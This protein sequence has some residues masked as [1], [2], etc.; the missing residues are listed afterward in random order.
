[1]TWREPHQWL[2]LV[3]IPFLVATY[4]AILRN[5]DRLSPQACRMSYMT[6]SYALETDFNSS[7]TR[8]ARR[9][10]LWLYREYSWESHEKLNGT[11]VLFIPGNAGSSRQVRSIA[12]S[13]TRQYYSEPYR[14]S[15]QFVNTE[16]KPL[17]VFAV[18]FNEDFSALHGPTLFAEREYASAAIDFI[19]SRYEPNTTIIVMGHSMGGIVALSLLPSPRISTIITMSTP[20]SL[21]PA[22]L[23]QRIEEIYKHSWDT[24]RNDSTSIL[25]I[26]GGATDLM[27][28]S[29]TC[30]MQHRL[31]SLLGQRRTVSTTCMEGAWTGVGHREMVWCHQVR[32]RVARAAIELGGAR[33][34]DQITNIIDRWFRDEMPTDRFALHDLL[35]SDSFEKIELPERQKLILHKIPSQPSLFLIPRSAS[36]FTLYVS[37]GGLGNLSPHHPAD[38]EVSVYH[39]RITPE[40]CRLLPADELRLIPDS[41]KDS[42]FLLPQ[43]GVDES[44]GISRYHSRL[45]NSGGPQVK[46]WVG[47]AVKGSDGHKSWIIGGFEDEHIVNLDD[48]AIGQKSIVFANLDAVLTSLAPLRGSIPVSLPRSALSTR[49][50]FPNLISSSL[51]VYR[52]DNLNIAG[53]CSSALLPPLILHKSNSSESHFHST[54]GQRVILIHTHSSGPF[55]PLNKE[56]RYGITL[57][58]YSSGECGIS[59]FEFTVDWQATLATWGLRYWTTVVAWSIG[60]VAIVIGQSWHEWENGEP[61]LPLNE[62]L[63]LFVSRKLLPLAGGLVFL[64][65]LPLNADFLLG[66]S[67]EMILSPLA[68]LVLVVSSGCVVITLNILDV[69]VWI[70]R[71]TNT[72]LR[73]ESSLQMTHLRK[74]DLWSLGVVLLLVATV[75]PSQVAFLVCFLIHLGTCIS[76][77]PASTSYPAHVRNMNEGGTQKAHFLLLLFWLLP[78]TAP[79]L[80]V[81]AR[82]LLTAGLTTPFDGDHDIIAIASFLVYTNLATLVPPTFERATFREVYISD[83]YHEQYSN[84]ISSGD[85]NS[86]EDALES[87][88]K[89]D[90]RS[91]VRHAR[92]RR[93]NSGALQSIE[94]LSGRKPVRL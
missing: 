7:W 20:H 34:D 50:S 40:N 54:D 44:E 63:S 68:V 30:S 24:L 21:P 32:W 57:D 64:S 78:L 94:L 66:N 31:N 8:L 41:S 61:F 52:I 16:I 45:E 83:L 93:K 39:C 77:P 79:V 2:A 67:G 28:P 82:T 36:G 74:R 9:Y 60:V 3:T 14:I 53:S 15:P 76:Q 33:S 37:R 72:L 27:I 26:C 91:A 1:M 18:D 5:P 11:P 59:S 80:V 89:R 22:R 70:A 46:E 58:I 47:V 85:E 35:L 87:M 71:K 73:R 19:L 43:E 10:S 48:G 88:K 55:I 92:V 62:A 17:D 69:L 84:G 29:E 6:P 51:L 86:K 13:A 56:E 75:I 42:H 4:V 90:T 49:I 25:S 65:C 81:W 23:D 12:S 38:F